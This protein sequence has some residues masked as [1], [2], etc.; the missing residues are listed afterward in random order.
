MV[1]AMT[2]GDIDTDSAAYLLVFR[3]TTPERYEEM[4]VDERRA[5]LER[6]NAWCDELA[7]EGRLQAGNT[8]APEGREVSRAGG[9]RAV[10]NTLDGPF[11]EAKELI[12]GYLLLTAASLEEATT[13]AEGCP[14]LP[15]G[16]EVEVRPVAAA[17]HLARSLGWAT[18]R[19]PA[20]RVV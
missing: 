11:A 6:W 16:M 15:Y 10:A 3:E 14:N 4:S 12:G 2:D 9:T 18:M 7:A 17:C 13:I 20:A 1:T 8:L 5:A 19:G